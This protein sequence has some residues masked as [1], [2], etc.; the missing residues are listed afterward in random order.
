MASSA[1]KAR[2][3]ISD[4]VGWLLWSSSDD[5]EAI[6]HGFGGQLTD[7]WVDC[8]VLCAKKYGTFVR[9]SQKNST[10]AQLTFFNRSL[11]DVDISFIN[12]YQYF[13]CRAWSA[14]SKTVLTLI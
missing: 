8:C 3:G 11:S 5:L 7:Q 10:F 6:G 1:T 14:L 2:G 9:T 4:S 12:K 13:I